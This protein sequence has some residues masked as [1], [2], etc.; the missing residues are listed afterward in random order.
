VS[1]FKQKLAEDLDARY[2]RLLAVIDKGMESVKT[3]W[4]SCPRCGKRSEVEIQDTRAAIA[5]A[6]FVASHAHGRPGIAAD[7]SDEERITFIRIVADEESDAI[8][9]FKLAEEFVPKD[10][11][12]AFVNAVGTPHWPITRGGE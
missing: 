11:W 2:E 4:V 5:A 3:T 7:D 1:D 8:R 12:L 10:R 6:E 9:I